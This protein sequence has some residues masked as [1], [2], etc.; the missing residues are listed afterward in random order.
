MARATMTMGFQPRRRGSTK[1]S[2]NL[3]R[4]AFL[5]SASLVFG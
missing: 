4:H 3:V 2:P 5:R 1:L